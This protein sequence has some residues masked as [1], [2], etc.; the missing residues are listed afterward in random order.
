MRFLDTEAAGETQVAR[1]HPRTELRLR[2][3]RG[4]SHRPGLCGRPA[5]ASGTAA[6]RLGLERKQLAYLHL[7]DARLVGVL[8]HRGANVQKFTRVHKIL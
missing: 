5:P 1:H 6:P 3:P 8:G 7:A 4:P 2:R